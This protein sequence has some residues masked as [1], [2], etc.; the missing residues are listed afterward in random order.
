[1]ELFE[2]HLASYNMGEFLVY[3]QRVAN[4]ITPEVGDYSMY[5]EY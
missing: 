4:L 5:I 2:E 3:Y 1:M